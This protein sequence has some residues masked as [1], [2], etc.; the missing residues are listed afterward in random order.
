MND[1]DIMQLE[2][3]IAL[4]PKKKANLLFYMWKKGIPNWVRQFIWLITIGNQ[5]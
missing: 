2:Q 5:L 4:K 3:E 1:H